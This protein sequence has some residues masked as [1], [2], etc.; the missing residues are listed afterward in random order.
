MCRAKPYSGCNIQPRFAKSRDRKAAL[1]DQI[2]VQ[3]GLSATTPRNGEARND[4]TSCA[5][6]WRFFKVDLRT[7]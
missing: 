3:Q 6:L 2:G 4:W 7:A 1:L 5:G